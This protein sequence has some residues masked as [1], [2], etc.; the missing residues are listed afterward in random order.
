MILMLVMRRNKAHTEQ[1]RKHE[2]QTGVSGSFPEQ[3][4]SPMHASD[5]LRSDFREHLDEVASSNGKVNVKLCKR[6]LACTD[7]LPAS[8][9]DQLD[10]PNGSSYGDAARHLLEEAR[11]DVPVPETK[12]PTRRVLVE[13][14]G[15]E[16][17]T[18]VRQV[19]LEVPE[20]VED[21]EIEDLCGDGIDQWLAEA[22]SGSEW[23]FEDSTGISTTEA[24]VEAEPDGDEDA[25]DL[26]LVR[27]QDGRLVP[28]AE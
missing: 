19:V 24:V 17:R 10:L 8:E 9:C 4:G 3:G 21:S 27:N 22:D 18:Y 13:L 26:S 1:K 15:E 11:V 2:W 12:K 20:D 16:T 7:I 14:T 23:D 28:E 6:L 5:D 25:A